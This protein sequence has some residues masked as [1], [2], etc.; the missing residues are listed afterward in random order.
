VEE[1]KRSRR[2]EV[3]VV[4]VTFEGRQGLLAGLHSKQEEGAVLTGRLKR[5]AGN[6]YDSNAIAVEA[7]GLPVGYIPKAL[8][9]KLAT[10]IDAGELIDV[11]A[12]RI[13]KGDKDGQTVYGARI[14]VQM[15]AETEKEAV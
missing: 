15:Q 8:A 3:A 2:F 4:G 11:A 5:E 6:R 9:A 1:T 14:D 13:I 7:D 10:H 12:V